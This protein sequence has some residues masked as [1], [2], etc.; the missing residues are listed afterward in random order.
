MSML[1]SESLTFA[2]L[3]DTLLWTAALIALVLVLRRPVARHFGPQMAYALW[4]LPL[5]RLILPPIELPAWLAPAAAETASTVAPVDATF[6]LILPPTTSSVIDPVAT[7]SPL[8]LLEIVIGL[9][10]VG[11]CSFLFLRFRG[12]FD[13]RRKLLAD[14]REVGRAGK[15]RLVETP[16][17]GAPLAFGVR[18]KVVALPQGFMASANLEARD[19]AVAHELAH[20]RGNDLLINIVVQPLFALHWFNPLGHLGWLALRRDQEAACDARVMAEQ[21]PDKKASYA[22]V[23]ASFAAGPN[24]AL[25][26][27]MACPVLG[28]KSIIHRLRS[29]QM[30]DFSSRRRIAGRGLL[31]AA[32]LAVPMT[33]SITYADEIAAAVPPAPAAPAAPAAP[34]ALYEPPLPPAPVGTAPAAPLPPTAPLAPIAPTP[35][36]AA[37]AAAMQAAA[38]AQ[39]DAAE[40]AEERIEKKMRIIREKEIEAAEKKHKMKIVREIHAKKSGEYMS[41][42]EIDEIMASVRSGLA[43]ADIAIQ[44]AKTI[45]LEFKQEGKDGQHTIV[46][47]SCEGDGVSSEKVREDGKKVVMICQSKIMAHALT[48]LKQAREQIATSGEMPDR[49]RKEVLKELDQQIAS[50]NERDS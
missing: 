3:A 19:L 1:S 40:E 4:A 35:P 7:Q 12:Y 25:A 38:E 34:T 50:W 20:H 46:E 39:A 17:T 37:L 43:D 44:E 14:A 13:M 6:S 2:W 10:L 31:V 30:S 48:G 36:A 21:E 49:L 32:A 11:A 9:W 41:E 33:A 8:P 18:D 47:M 23:I 45:G 24:V 42:A 16:G 28:D 26:A 22:S 5:F 15:V 27:P 29:L